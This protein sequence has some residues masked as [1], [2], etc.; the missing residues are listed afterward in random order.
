MRDRRLKKS[1]RFRRSRSRKNKNR[2]RNRN[3]NKKSRR[4]R[5]QLTGGWGTDEETVIVRITL[6][7][8]GP[9][10]GL[11]EIWDGNI[12]KGIVGVVK[13]VEQ[14]NTGNKI[15][16]IPVIFGSTE[17]PQKQISEIQD[18]YGIIK[19]GKHEQILIPHYPTIVKCKKDK[20][21]EYYNGE[22][23]EESIKTWILK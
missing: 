19:D 5:F 6:K 7:G 1:S 16:F 2:N 13:K 14:E 15:K 22:R 10:D 21:Y 12:E 11:K 23:D 17:D 18:E 9:C 8:C 4:V 3:R 20:A